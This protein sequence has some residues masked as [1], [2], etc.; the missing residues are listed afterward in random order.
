MAGILTA[1]SKGSVTGFGQG[2]IGQA[3][4]APGFKEVSD[5][6]G[7]VTRAAQYGVSFE[8]IAKDIAS[9]GADQAVAR[10]IPAFI[11]DLGK[12]IDTY[13]RE[14]GG[15]MLRRIQAKV[16]FLREKLPIKTDVTG[17]KIETEPTNILFGARVK[18]AVD[19]AVVKEIDRLNKVGQAPTLSDPTRYGKFRSLE[20]KN[21]DKVR[22]EFNAEY[23]KQ[24]KRL[25]ATGSYKR[26]SDS[27]KKNQL[28][29][30]RKKVSDELKRK[31]L[32]VS[33]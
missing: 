16:P 18:T 2:V 27:A 25:I 23:S 17:R 32:K 33:K 31:H 9:W 4:K 24:V 19:N 3:L 1:R 14:T 28:N 7:D 30:I 8:N 5:L 11:T 13:E 20:T 12:L 10:S 26:M 6:I 22:A 21:K 29:K 15:E